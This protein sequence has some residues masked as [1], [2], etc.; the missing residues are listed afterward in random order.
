MAYF[1]L[2]VSKKTVHQKSSISEFIVFSKVP[3]F[4]QPH[5][6]D[7]LLSHEAN[8]TVVGNDASQLTLADP[9]DNMVDVVCKKKLTHTTHIHTL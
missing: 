1:I 4:V 3:K 6:M 9:S 5:L 8:G 7:T 2:I